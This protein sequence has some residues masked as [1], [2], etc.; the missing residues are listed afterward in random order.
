MAVRLRSCRARV[1]RRNASDAETLLWRA[2]RELSLPFKVRR[3]HPVGRYVVDFAIP[4]RKLA[5]EVDGGQ[6]A[7]NAETDALRTTEIRQRGYRVVRFWNHEVLNNLEGVLRIIL[8]AVAIP[9]PHPD[10]LRPQGRRG[11]RP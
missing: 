8:A 2:L 6:H 3:Q 9:P 11:R 10:P 1:L 4:T 5:I 7:A